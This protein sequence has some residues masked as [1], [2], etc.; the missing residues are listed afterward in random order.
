MKH[1]RKVG[2]L[3][4]AGLLPLAVLTGC[5]G[6]ATAP[7]PDGTGATAP[8]GETVE[9][10]LG[11]QMAAETSFGRAAN[12]L[13]EMVAERSDGRITIE[14]FTDGVLGDELEMWESMQAGTLDMSVT[15]PGRISNFVPEYFVYELPY[16]FTDYA[17]RDA[18]ADSP[19]G[20]KIDAI[21]TEE[22]GIV[23]LGQMGGSARYLLT[24]D[25]EAPDLAD[26]DGV[27]MRVQ[28]AQ[29][30]V[31]TWT[32]LGTLPVTV[33]Y[34]ETYTALQTGVVNA[35]ENELSTFTTMKW[36]EPSNY[37][38]LTAHSIGMRPLV[39]SEATFSKLSESD[40]QL[41]REAG[42]EAALKAVE[43]ERADEEAAFAELQELGITLVDLTDKQEW[44]DATAPIR[45][46]FAAEHD[47][48]P[49]IMQEIA[50]TK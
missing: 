18:V 19:V 48:M 44:I 45:D 8:E 15:S 49:E 39:I 33:A 16:I 41:L 10:R 17:H 34:N 36:Y 43:Y 9:L 21:L 47:G 4:A 26:I 50:A 20:E 5:G 42:Q 2:S 40:Q 31:D 46:N 3:I 6:A 24:T 27:K 38:M 32:A 25:T 23:V 11:V 37:L 12:D 30:V 28:E 1:I 29:I 13:A 14:V 22:A 35:A 7:S